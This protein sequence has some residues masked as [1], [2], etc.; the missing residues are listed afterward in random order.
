MHTH[1]GKVLRPDVHFL[2]GWHIWSTLDTPQVSITTHPYQAGTSEKVGDKTTY[3]ASREQIIARSKST[4]TGFMDRNLGA[5]WT[6]KTVSDVNNITLQQATDALGLYFQAG[7]I[8][9]YPRAK[10]FGV[11]GSA[12][13]SWDEWQRTTY[14]YGFAQFAQS[15]V[16]SGAA[17]TTIEETLQHPYHRYSKRTVS[18]D[19]FSP[20]D[21]YYGDIYRN[22]WVLTDISLGCKTYNNKNN[23]AKQDRVAYTGP[24]LWDGATNSKLA[25]KGNFDPCPQGWKVAHRGNV[26]QLATGQGFQ[27]METGATAYTNASQN[28]FQTV[29]SKKFNNVAAGLYVCYDG[30]NVDFWP[31]GGYAGGKITFNGSG[32]YWAA[33]YY[34]QDPAHTSAAVKMILATSKSNSVDYNWPQTSSPY[35]IRC[36][37]GTK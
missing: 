18:G 2:W 3:Y 9:P 29:A 5:T 4:P 25:T 6:P 15:W 21:G 19:A 37:K 7:N 12:D 1:S 16:T 33:Q 36:V 31:F 23:T 17:K 22:S 20:I 26:Y 27:F 28:T 30:T 11:G 13:P 35:Q 14:Q 10:E 24:V 34:N 8:A 32:Y